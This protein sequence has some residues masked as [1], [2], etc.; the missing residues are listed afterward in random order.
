MT[1]YRYDGENQRKRK[2]M[3]DGVRYFIHGPGGQIIAE[4]WFWV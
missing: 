2:E 4:S 1:T 3:P